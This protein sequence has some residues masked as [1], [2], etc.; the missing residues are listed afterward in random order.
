MKSDPQVANERQYDSFKIDV[1]RRA[2]FDPRPIS[3]QQSPSQERINAFLCA[4]SAKETHWSLLLKIVYPDGP[5]D[6]SDKEN[7]YPK[8]RDDFYTSLMKIAD[9]L[10]PHPDYEGPLEVK[11]TRGQSKNGFWSALR[12]LHATASNCRKIAHFTNDSAKMH[13]LQTH[14]W[15]MNKITTRAMKYGTK[16]E[17]DAREDYVKKRLLDDP[18]V[19]VV[20]SGMFIHT[21]LPGLSCSPDGM[22][23]SHNNTP[24]LLEI[25]CPYKLRDIPPNDFDKLIPKERLSGYYLKRSA[26]NKIYLNR[27]HGYYDQIQ[28][29]LGIIG[30]KECDLVVWSKEGTVILPIAFD[31]PRWTSIKNKL[32]SFHWN[33][34]VPEYFLRRTVRGLHPISID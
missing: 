28:M 5:L 32:Q 13:H 12:C 3:E 17:E 7:Y 34:Q 31:E 21:Q 26:N 14:L 30:V 33:Y 23:V 27:N 9:D 25:K 2:S 24:K 19:K 29:N 11:E 1:L 8:L 6:N 4:M 18:S 20:E 16:H 10:K 15:T 22:V